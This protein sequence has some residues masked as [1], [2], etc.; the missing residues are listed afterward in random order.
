[1]VSFV[2]QAG[3]HF[4]D[5]AGADHQHTQTA[6]ADAAANGQGQLARQQHL[7]GSGS[8]RRSSQPRLCSW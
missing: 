5:V 3:L 7:V 8:S 6:L 4:A 1:M 2:P